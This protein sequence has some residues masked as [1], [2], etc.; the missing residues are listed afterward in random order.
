MPL[1]VL[2]IETVPDLSIW[3]PKPKWT[4]APVPYGRMPDGKPFT[5]ANLGTLTGFE[6]STGVADAGLVMETP[7]A[8]PFAQRVV[9]VAWVD[10]E[11]GDTVRYHYKNHVAM[12]LWS[13]EIP[14]DSEG[15]ILHAFSKAEHE[16]HALLVTWNGRR[17]DMPVLSMRSLKHGVPFSFFYD[18]SD[19]RYRYSQAGHIDLMDFLSDFGAAT[20]ASLG[21]IARLIGL[22]GKT[23]ELTGSGVA[24]EYAKGDDPEAME[25][26]RKYC[27][28]DAL[29]TALVFLRTR[30][31]IGKINVEEH[32]AALAS[33][34]VSLPGECGLSISIGPK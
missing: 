1:R 34:P 8:P 32:D 15:L 27:L 3:K 20:N 26:V 23:G 17:F 24:A 10:L 33:F 9:A 11:D 16:D 12:C 25:R 28:S 5:E 14:D 22:P 19:F 21:D 4:L 6:G 7:F 30:L 31:H 29:Q 18:D 13:H 2:D